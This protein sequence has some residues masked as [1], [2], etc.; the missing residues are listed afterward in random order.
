MESTETLTVILFLI[1]VLITILAVGCVIG[2]TASFVLIRNKKIMT[3]KEFWEMFLSSLGCL[4]ACILVW[5]S[6]DSIF[7]KL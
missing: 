1:R 2:L 5:I 4:I 7:I 6:L 3:S